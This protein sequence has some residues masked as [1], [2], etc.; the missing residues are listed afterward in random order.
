MAKS[1]GAAALQGV[2][3]TAAL[4]AIFQKPKEDKKPEG[5][6]DEGTAD[7]STPSCPG[8]KRGP[9]EQDPARSGVHSPRTH[10]KAKGRVGREELGGG[11]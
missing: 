1:G 9:S 7:A 4:H 11:V 10:S 6:G 2:G 3:G 8:G 5:Q